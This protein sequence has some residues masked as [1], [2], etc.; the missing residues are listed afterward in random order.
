MMTLRFQIGWK[1]W[2]E[3]QTNVFFHQDNADWGLEIVQS[4]DKRCWPVVAYMDSGWI[5][6]KMD[7]LVQ[8]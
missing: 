1:V 8:L 6:I 2:V 7:S 4:S 5:E 3:V